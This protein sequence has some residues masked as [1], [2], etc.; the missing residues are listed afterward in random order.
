MIYEIARKLGIRFD[1]FKKK[2]RIDRE[3]LC[4]RRERFKNWPGFIALVIIDVRVR[5]GP[6]GFSY[7]S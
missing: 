1:C 5:D 4:R 2:K 6:E 7:C 3:K